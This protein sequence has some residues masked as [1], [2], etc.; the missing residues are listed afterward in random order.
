MVTIFNSPGPE[1]VKFNRLV[2]RPTY[3]EVL[4]P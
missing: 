2:F 1:E 3:L 4:W